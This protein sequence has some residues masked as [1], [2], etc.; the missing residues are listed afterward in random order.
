[1]S[2]ATLIGLTF[3]FCTALVGFAGFD[4]SLYGVVIAKRTGLSGSWVG[5]TLLATV[6]SLPELATGIT[7]VTVANALNLALGDAL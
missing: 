5:L 1:M 4:L 7:S 2:D 3:L 6:T